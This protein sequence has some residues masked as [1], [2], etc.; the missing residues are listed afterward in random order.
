METK[1]TNGDVV[2]LVNDTASERG[3]DTTGSRS[4][5]E[6]DSCDEVEFRVVPRQTVARSDTDDVVSVSDE[7][8]D[9]DVDEVPLAA[10]KCV[11]C[12]SRRVKSCSNNACKR[13]CVRLATDCDVHRKSTSVKNKGGSNISVKSDPSSA[14]A[15]P[16]RKLRKPV[17]KNEFKESN[18]A[19][20]EETVTL[21]CVRDFFASKKLS[22][23][24]LNDQIRSRRVQGALASASSGHKRSIKDADLKERVLDALKKRRAVVSAN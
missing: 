2:D 15:R 16:P 17:L 11:S 23:S 1:S 13:C 12:S 18:I 4:D 19:Y 7:K 10:N 9:E 22:Q 8:T 14:D 21:F 3:D 20:Y 6:T 24:L 5:N